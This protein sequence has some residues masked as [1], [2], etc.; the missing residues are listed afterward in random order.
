[1][2]IVLI[3]ASKELVAHL[4]GSGYLGDDVK[5]T[6]LDDD[7]NAVDAVAKEFDIAAFSGDLFN[8]SLYDEAG[9]S[10]AHVV[11]A[12]HPDQNKNII[13]CAIAKYHG[14]EK[15]IAVVNDDSVG[16]V[17]VRLGLASGYVNRCKA[18]LQ[19]LVSEIIDA[20]VFEL[21]KRVGE[22]TMVYGYLIFIDASRRP[23]IV[24]KRVGELLEGTKE[25]ANVLMVFR[26]DG[27]ILCQPE[28]D[29]LIE[30][31]DEVLLYAKDFETVKKI[32]RI[33]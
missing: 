26:A 2:R 13:A 11:V 8:P 19:R 20:D 29:T 3:G 17:L 7:I 31:G 30:E 6:V 5:I 24:G 21:S 10:K 16:N 1:M 33:P 27:T 18:L 9:V 4:L 28:A 12:A 25:S 22:R 32:L 23:A 15:T 14:V